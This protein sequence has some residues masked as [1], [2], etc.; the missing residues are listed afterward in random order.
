MIY[1]AG[2]FRGIDKGRQSKGQATCCS[3]CQVSRSISISEKLF[4]KKKKSRYVCLIPHPIFYVINSSL[5]PGFFAVI[6]HRQAQG[7]R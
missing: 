5:S 1:A 2:K 3:D 4:F 6:V 7:M